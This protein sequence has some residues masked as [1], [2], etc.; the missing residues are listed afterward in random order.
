MNILRNKYVVIGLGVVALAMIANSLKP[1]WQR[2]GRAAPATSARAQT[3]AAAPA[4]IPVA[5][6]T[7]TPSAAR[8]QAEAALPDQRVD[9][10]QVGWTFNGAPRRDPFQVMG[11]APGNLARLYPPVSE[12]MDLTAIWRQTGSSL[13]VI[14][15]KIVGEGDTVVAAVDSRTG[16]G[17]SNLL[18]FTVESIGGNSVWLEGPSGREELEFRPIGAARSSPAAKGAK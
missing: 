4:S 16:G 1:L 9:L 18:R 5:S 7:A 12:L 8:P 15:Y 10:T 13:A 3:Q 2:G 11:P 6:N 17:G 14:N